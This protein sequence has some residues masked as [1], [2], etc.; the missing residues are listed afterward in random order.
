MHP[1][2]PK[3]FLCPQPIKMAK[4]K[5]PYIPL[6]IG[7][8]E[9]D[10]NTV[11]VTAEGAWL[12]IVFK[13]FKG[14]KS[15][16]YKTS[17][18]ALQN[19]WK[20]HDL[21]ALFVILDELRDNNVCGL[22]VENAEKVTFFNRRMIRENEI[23]VVRSN[24]VSKRYKKGSTKR[25]QKDKK[26]STKSLHPYEYEYDIDTDNKTVLKER[27][28]G[29]EKPQYQFPF[30]TDL[31]SYTLEACELNQHAQ[32]GNKNTDFVLASWDIFL[33]ERINDPPGERLAYRELSDLTKYFLNWIRT[34]FPKH[35]TSQQRVTK[36]SDRPGTSA[37]QIDGLTALRTAVINGDPDTY[38]AECEA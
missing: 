32:T 38:G 28:V 17:T 2:N 35:G 8:W 1:L 15:G 4:G 30:S 6:Y 12:K 37:A 33:L 14:D 9:Q 36:N 10:T 22:E 18:K 25:L 21:I 11:S 26:R 13:M 16:I 5:Q 34:K 24:S 19:L 23:S 29:E 3:V 20:V 27:G 7:D 31:P